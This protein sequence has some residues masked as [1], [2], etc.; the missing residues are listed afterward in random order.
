M[1]LTSAAAIP[2]AVLVLAGTGPAAALMVAAPNPLQRALTAPVVVTGKVT[3]IEADAVEAEPFP[4]APQKVTYKVAIV[5]LDEA[6]VGAKG[7]THVKVG[8]IPPPPPQPIDPNAPRVGGGF[9]RPGFD[10]SLKADQTGCFFLRKHP[11]ADFYTFDYMTQPLNGSAENYKDELAKVKQALAAVA[12]PMKALKAEKAED[13]YTAA[14]AVVTKYRTPVGDTAPKQVDVPAEES[15]LIFAAL[16]EADWSKH[17][18]NTPHPTQLLQQ[19]G[20]MSPE[21]FQVQFN[22][23]GDYNAVVKAA[24]KEWMAGKGAKY[25]LKK[26]AAPDAK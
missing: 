25:T 19:A 10:L 4:K 23:Q 21:G 11:T 20:V 5:K 16:L 26:F 1:R 3:S 24:F 12:D 9:R 7:L 6:L 14:A 22:G 17:D 8:F 15:K 2:A 18:F 13:R